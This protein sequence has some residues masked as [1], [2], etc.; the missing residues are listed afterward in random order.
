MSILLY[1]FVHV[2]THAPTEALE[3][4]HLRTCCP[5]QKPSACQHDGRGCALEREGVGLPPPLTP[6]KAKQSK[7][8]REIDGVPTTALASERKTEREKPF[9]ST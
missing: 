4:V 1:V 9:L 2:D 7:A 6:S 3:P 5:A 8:K